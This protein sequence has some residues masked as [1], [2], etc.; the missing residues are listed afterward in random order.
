MVLIPVPLLARTFV[1]ASG[2][3]HLLVST[4]RGSLV[5]MVIMAFLSGRGALFLLVMVMVVVVMAVVMVVVMGMALV[6]PPL[7]ASGPVGLTPVP[8]RLTP[9]PESMMV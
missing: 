2:T 1:S 5:V 8:T 6:F 9:M 4:E 7:R 3:S